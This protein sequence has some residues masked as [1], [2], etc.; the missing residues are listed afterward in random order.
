MMP[1]DANTHFYYSKLGTT[2]KH[3]K[4]NNA[5]LISRRAYCMT[6]DGIDGRAI[7]HTERS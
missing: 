3:L 5:Q 6:R 1:T 7:E 2:E 4:R